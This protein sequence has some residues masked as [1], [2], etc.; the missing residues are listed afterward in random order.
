[1]SRRALVVPVAALALLAALAVGLW[2]WAGVV[3]PGYDSAI[4]LG[5]AWFIA[6][7]VAAGAVAKRL[8]Q[9]RRALRTTFLAATVLTVA[10]FAWTSLR[11]T[12][13]DEPLET[14]TPASRLAPEERPDVDDLLAPQ[15]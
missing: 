11:E 10:A 7:S 9:L 13:V 4:A 3:A 14:G 1:M 5:V 2:F 8:P 6:V 12:E 15:P